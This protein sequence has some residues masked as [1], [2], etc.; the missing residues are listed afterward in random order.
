[1]YEIPHRLLWLGFLFSVSHLEVS[2]V[3]KNYVSH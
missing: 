1:M 2:N 3:T